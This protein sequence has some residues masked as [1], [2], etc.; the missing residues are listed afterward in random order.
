MSETQALTDALAAGTVKLPEFS[1]AIKRAVDAGQILL[2]VGEVKATVEKRT[3]AKL[4]V[5]TVTQ[6]DGWLN[7]ALALTEGSA[8]KVSGLFWYGFDLGVRNSLRP[9]LVAELEGPEKII[10]RAA[11]DLFAAGCYDSIDEARTA[12]IDRRKKRNLPV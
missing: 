4:Y 12:V 2:D 10:A 3:A 8:K 7:G 5:K 11:K 6:G 1:E 9:A